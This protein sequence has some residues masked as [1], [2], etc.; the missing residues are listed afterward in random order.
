MSSLCISCLILG[1]L[2]TNCLS[3]LFYYGFNFHFIDLCFVVYF[4]DLFFINFDF[5]VDVN[6]ER[7]GVELGDEHHRFVNMSEIKREN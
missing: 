5:L 1:F 2:K 6:L 3:F 4:I 7:C